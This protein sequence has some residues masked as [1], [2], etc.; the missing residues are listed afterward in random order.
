MSKHLVHLF[1]VLTK[2]FRRMDK[3][4]ELTGVLITNYC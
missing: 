2:Q 1:L 4:L 3:E